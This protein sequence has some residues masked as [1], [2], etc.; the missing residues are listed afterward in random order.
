M[1]VFPFTDTAPRAA[2]PVVTLTL[3]LINTMVFLW[4]VSLPPRALDTLLTHAAL[5]PIRYTEPNVARHA[6]LDPSNWWPLLTN[7]FMH[8]G[9]LHLISNMWFLWIFGPAMEARFT[10]L[11]F[12]FL[13][14][15]GAV[16]ASL[17]HVFTHPTSV[18]P[19]LGASGAIAAIIGAHALTY[20][21]ARVITVVLLGF[22][23]LFFPLPAA[24]FAVIWFA[25]QLVQGSMELATPHMASS[26]AWWAH[27][28]GFVF[29]ALFAIAASDFGAHRPVRTRTW[30]QPQRRHVP[31]IRP[32]NWG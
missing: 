22:I 16:A 4:M 24:L 13:Y 18:D 30:V 1:P 3:I 12:A 10:R 28:G 6:G 27:I 8:G 26:V 11:G 25:L 5:V 7:T 17:V 9:W 31:T 19:A 32:R 23:P 21:S 2:F 20:P 29:G 15:A 14:V